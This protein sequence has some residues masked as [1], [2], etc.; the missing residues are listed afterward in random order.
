MQQ[1]EVGRKP[2]PYE[3]AYT[4][5]YGYAKLREKLKEKDDWPPAPLCDDDVSD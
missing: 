3:K 2:T 4:T 5:S 1:V